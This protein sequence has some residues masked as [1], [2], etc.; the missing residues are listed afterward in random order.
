MNRKTKYL[1]IVSFDGLST[2]DF[3]YISTLPNFKEFIEDS[4]YCKNVYSIY[5]SL[6]YPAHSSIVTG[7][8][9]NNHGVIN[10]TFLQ[11][12]TDSP[13]WHWHRKDIKA[14]T[15]Y[16]IAIENKMKVAALLWPVTAKSKIQYNMPEIFANRKWQNQ[17]MVSLLNGSP[18]YQIQMNYKYGSIRN[19]RSQPELDNFT[20]K[21]LNDTLKNKKPDITMVHFTD[22]DTIRHKFGFDSKEAIEALNRHDERL[23]EIINTLKSSNMYDESTLIL[24]GDHSSLNEDKVIYLNRLL[25]EKGFIEVD[26]KGLINNYSAIL[27][28]CDGSAY[29]Y[30]KNNDK[31][32]KEKVFKVIKDFNKKYNCI[33]DILTSKQAKKLG[34]DENC[35]FMLEAK[36]GYY[37]LDDHNR[38]VIE[39]I[40]KEDIG[41]IPHITLSTHGYSP[42]KEDYT[43]VFMAK[44]CGIKKNII[45]DKMSLIDYANT[46]S[47]LLGFEMNDIDGKVLD[48]IIE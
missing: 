11:L 18:L 5:P 9:P 3:D 48:E 32:I 44:G 12:N 24:L 36:K 7:K 39:D 30:T 8:Y 10:N 35:T 15:F 43:T 37:F 34:A 1:V 4:S 29:I 38:K 31:K 19:S 23:G 20:S 13:D 33:E 2:L 46:F 47:K 26:E 25:K 40:K 14:E 17:I 45:I 28:N 16:D 27:K 42:C 22:L 41:N 6:T 21:C